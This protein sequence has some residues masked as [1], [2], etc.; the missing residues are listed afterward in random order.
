[1]VDLLELKIMEMNVVFRIRNVTT[2]RQTKLS[3]WC[4]SGE[5]D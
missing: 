2:I 3:S 5:A 4:Y 1:M